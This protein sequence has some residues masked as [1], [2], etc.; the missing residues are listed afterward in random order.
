MS[1]L[2]LSLWMQWNAV[3]YEGKGGEIRQFPQFRKS[4]DIRGILSSN[5][6]NGVK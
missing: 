3:H 1:P 6:M 5:T 4:W 2:L